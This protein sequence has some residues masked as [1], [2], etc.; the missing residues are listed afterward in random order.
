M[1][2]FFR[3]EYN[4]ENE[5]KIEKSLLLVDAEMYTRGSEGGGRGENKTPLE[6]LCKQNA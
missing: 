1:K 4:F 6:K 2:T 3:L 5:T